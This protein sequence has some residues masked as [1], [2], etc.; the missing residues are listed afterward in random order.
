[1]TAKFGVGKATA[2][3]TLRRVTYVLHCVAPRFITWPKNQV[4]V[5][6][7]ERFERSCGF[8][9]VIGAIGGTH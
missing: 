6:V 8:L 9:N 5:N 2:F 1:M 3:R 7:M 4:A